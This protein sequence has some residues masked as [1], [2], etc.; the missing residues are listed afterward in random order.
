[1]Q[2]ATV[3]KH[4]TLPMDTYS[5]PQGLCLDQQLRMCVRM[6]LVYLV[7]QPYLAKQMA[8]GKLHRNAKVYKYVKKKKK[9]NE[10]KKKSIDSI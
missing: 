3:A 9:R 2:H 7:L 8:T 1:M 4:Q 10:M 6:G 5:Q